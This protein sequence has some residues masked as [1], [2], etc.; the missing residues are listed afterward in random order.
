MVKIK[1]DILS[2][3]RIALMMLREARA[4]QLGPP[5]KPGTRRYDPNDG[6]ARNVDFELF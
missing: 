5:P 1:D 3:V 2:A 6:L 4:V